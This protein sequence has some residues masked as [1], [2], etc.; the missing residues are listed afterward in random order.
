M[1]QY[2]HVCKD[3]ISKYGHV[4]R[5]Q[6][7]VHLGVML[8][9]PGGYGWQIGLSSTAAGPPKAS[10]HP[11]TSELLAGVTDRTSHLESWLLEDRVCVYTSDRQFRGWRAG[12]QLCGSFRS[13]APHWPMVA[14]GLG[15]PPVGEY[16]SVQTP[17]GST[18]GTGV[19]E[20]A[21]S[22]HLP[23]ARF[24]VRSWGEA[25]SW[26]G[27]RQFPGEETGCGVLAPRV[28]QRGRQTLW[29]R[30]GRSRALTGRRELVRQ[31]NRQGC[32]GL[33]SRG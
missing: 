23:C 19:S 20:S 17:L 3:L 21:S 4:P 10:M 5:F 24:P 15:L 31:Q 9:N 28:A 1:L 13:S 14:G 11:L 7:V 16:G 29:R 26:R 22:G 33:R 2:K 12:E 32:W 30:W 18:E 8:F 6:R 25:V 27:D